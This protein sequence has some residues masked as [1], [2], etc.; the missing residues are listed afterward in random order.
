[1]KSFDRARLLLV[2]ARAALPQHSAD[3]LRL[4][5]CVDDLRQPAR[6]SL[7]AKEERSSR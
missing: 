6:L 4:S 7:A 1:M 2:D 3:S 5:R